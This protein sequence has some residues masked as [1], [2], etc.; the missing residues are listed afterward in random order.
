MIILLP[1]IEF[2]EFNEDKKTGVYTGMYNFDIN[3][4]VTIEPDSD[5][6]TIITHKNR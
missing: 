3:N 4:I 2:D 6:D 1:F 5:G